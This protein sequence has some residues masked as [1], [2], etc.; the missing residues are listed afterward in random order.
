MLRVL[1][2]S[3]YPF[4]DTKSVV[5]HIDKGAIGGSLKKEV[6]SR[7]NPE[8][9]STKTLKRRDTPLICENWV[10]CLLCDLLLAFR[11]RVY[12]ANGFAFLVL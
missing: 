2:S 4:I 6:T 8:E 12:Q 11:D 5:R 1:W 9:K 10:R 7:G 3:G